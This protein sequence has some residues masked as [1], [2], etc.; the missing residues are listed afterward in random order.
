MLE[1][2]MASQVDSKIGEALDKFQTN[3]QKNINTIREEIAALENKL[4]ERIEQ[5]EIEKQR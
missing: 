4:E 1:H 2:Q 3:N 5:E